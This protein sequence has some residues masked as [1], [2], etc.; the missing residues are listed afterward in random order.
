MEALR[1]RKAARTRSTILQAALSLFE[2][3]GYSATSV[4]DIAKAAE[5]SLPTLFRYFPSKADLVFADD[6]A[7]VARWEAAFDATAPQLPLSVALRAA[8]QAVM[9]G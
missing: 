6:E 9:A 1:A 2:K 7:S 4:E 5:I 3:H 8:S